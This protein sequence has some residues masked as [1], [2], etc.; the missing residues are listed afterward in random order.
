MLKNM[1]PLTFFY[2]LFLMSILHVI[3]SK[4]IILTIRCIITEFYCS[5]YNQHELFIYLDLMVKNRDTSNTLS[6]EPVL[7]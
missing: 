6:G 7:N 1:L 2:L 4:I 5:M 3:F